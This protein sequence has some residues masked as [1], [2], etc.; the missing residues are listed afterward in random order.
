LL[1]ILFFIV[2][3]RAKSAC[4][5]LDDATLVAY[6]TFDSGSVQ[7]SGPNYL[8]GIATSNVTTVTGYVNQAFYFGSSAAYFY[9][10]GLIALG[11]VNNAFSF[12]FWIKPTAYNNGGTILHVAVGTNGYSTG[13]YAWCLPFIG[14]DSSN[15]L[16][17]QVW[18]GSPLALTGSVP[19]LNV[20]THIVETYSST[21]GITLYVN[22]TQVG[23]TGSANYSASTVA[24][25]I[26]LGYYGTSGSL[27]ATGN[28][29][30]GPF[31]GAVD[32]LRI[33]SRELSSADACVLANQV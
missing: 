27:C 15:R 24:D 7:D 25:Y 5:I 30:P 12:S 6:Y 23:R 28:I 29:I 2:S 8:T 31:Y 17:A 3:N 4:E 10:G 18:T 16:I 11:T 21:N 14:L 26:F 32:E 19:P 33:Y 13:R 9:V 22:G 1:F 20:W